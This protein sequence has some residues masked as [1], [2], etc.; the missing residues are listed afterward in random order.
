MSAG[1]W[2]AL[3]P[4]PMRSARR[5]CSASQIVS[6]PVDSPA[7]GTL[8][9]PA[10][11]AAAKCGANCGRGTPISGPPR[12]KLTSPSGRCCR[13]TSRVMSA[14]GSAGLPRDVEAPSQGQVVLG[15]RAEPGVLDG[16]AHGLGGDATADVGVRRHGELGVADVLRGQVLRHLV[17]Q[18]PH[19]LLVAD[20]VDHR[21]V[22]LDEV[23]EVREAEVVGEQRRIGRDGARALVP[24]RERR[25]RGGSG[26]ADVVHVELRLGQPGHEGLQVA[27]PAESGTAIPSGLRRSRDGSGT[28][29]AHAPVLDRGLREPHGHPLPELGALAVAHGHDRGLQQLYDGAARAQVDDHG[30]EDLTDVRRQDRPPRRGRWRRGRARCPRRTPSAISSPRVGSAERTQSGTGSPAQSE[31]QTSSPYRSTSRRNGAVTCAY[32]APTAAC[33]VTAGG[34][35]SKPTQPGAAEEHR[36]LL[37][38]RGVPRHG[39]GR[40]RRRRRR[41]ASRRATRRRARART[42]EGGRR[43]AGRPAASSGGSRCR[44]RASSLRRRCR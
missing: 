35:P 14:A 44:R 23:R 41:M 8:R 39:A 31:A 32:G 29:E 43:R 15:L 24:G 38:E 18:R 3:M 4:C 10:A 37:E 12:P 34:S 20:Q 30:L 5:S 42:G 19:V 1:S 7:C 25:D 9:S 28:G 6:A 17:G 2:T 13:A 33:V 26:G 21:Q 27:H 22:D 40:A 11:R 16:L 36:C